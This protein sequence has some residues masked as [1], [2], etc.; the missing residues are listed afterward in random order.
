MAAQGATNR[1]IAARLYL[2]TKTIEMQ[3][4]CAYRKLDITLRQQL[5]AV[6][7]PLSG[8]QRI[9]DLAVII[10]PLHEIERIVAQ[11]VVR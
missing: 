11:R 7:G 5:A 8:V 6:L 9:E 1:E 2:S 10:H 4:G 3:P